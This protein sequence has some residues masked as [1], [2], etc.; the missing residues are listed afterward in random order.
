MGKTLTYKYVKEFF[1]EQGCELLEDEYIG[2]L[3][4]M[5]YRCSCNNISKIT[6]NSFQ[7]GSRCMKCALK[8]KSKKQKHTYEYVRQYYKDRGCELLEKEYIDRY[9]P[10]K[11]KCIC[12][13]I[14]RIFFDSFQQKQK[15]NCKKCEGKSRSG[16]NNYRW[17]EDRKVVKENERFRHKCYQMLKKALKIT[18]QK[19]NSRT[20]DLLGYTVTEL[21][22]YIHNHP[23][24]DNVKDKN[25]H[26]DHIFPLKAFSDYGIKDIKLINSLANL[27]PLS[28]K[29]NLIK[30]YQ[31]NKNKFKKW[32]KEK[33]YDI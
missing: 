25:W 15:I 11:Y 17:I 26:L 24:W 28:Q 23:N 20:K 21:Q 16:K 32:L 2:Y 18:S 27:Q 19:K 6:F 4:K 30:S 14:S 31:Y 33:D 12:G 3:T 1:E 10:M 22:N 7:Q 8:I 9:T 13:N 5:K 29:E